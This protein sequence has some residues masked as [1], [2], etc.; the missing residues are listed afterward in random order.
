MS[1]KNFIEYFNSL[2]KMGLC[3]FCEKE[4]KDEVFRDKKSEREFK[5]SGACQKCQ[6]ETFKEGK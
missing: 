6:D 2:R 4:I 5:Q 1:R 3:P